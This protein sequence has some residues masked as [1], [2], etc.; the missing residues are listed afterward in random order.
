MNERYICIHGHFYQPPREN[1]WLE[2]IELQ[3]SAFPYHDWNERITAE[4]YES[5]AT[6][7]ILNGD[8]RIES[9]VNNYARISFNFGPTLM[10]WLEG[11]APN[12][13]AA[14]V[15]AD[16][17]STTR[18]GGHGSAMAQCYN[19]SIMPLNNS[20]DKYTQVMWGIRDFTHRFG[21]EPEG[22]WLPE[23]AVDLESLDMMAAAGITFTVLAPR[24]A[25]AVRDKGSLKW[26]DVN[27][28]N[29]DPTMPYECTLPSGR[30]IAIFFYDGPI[31]QGIAFED[32]LASGENLAGRLAGAFNDD[33]SHPQ[34]VHIATDG[35][36]YGHHHYRGEMALSYAL[37][38][39]E[40]NKLANL[41]N[42]A[43]YLEKHPPTREARIYENSSWS[44]IHG[45]ERWRADCGCST[46]GRPGWNQQWRLPL[47]TA[48][49][50]LRDEVAPE[51]EES[52]ATFLRDPW[53][54]RDDYVNFILDR[55]DRNLQ[56]FLESNQIRPLQD[57]EV[58]S[59]L[60]ALE[61]QR[62]AMMMY[63]SCGWFFD[64]L[65]GIETSQVIMYAGRVVQLA[66]ELLELDLEEPFLHKLEA[67]KSN[68]PEHRD[69]RE[70]YLKFVKPAIVGL[71]K[72]G[73]HFAVSSMFRDYDDNARIFAFDVRRIHSKRFEK[74]RTRMCVGHIKV[75]SRITCE[76]DDLTFGVLH[77]GDHNV[78]GGVRRFQ[79]EDAYRKLNEEMDAVLDRA[80]LPEMIRYM[81]ANF[82]AATYSLKSLFKDEQRAI[83]TII[84]K[85]QLAD[86]ETIFRREYERHSPMMRFIDDLFMPLPRPFQTVAEYALTSM[87]NEAFA[88]EELD[89]DRIEALIKDATRGNIPLDTK[90]LEI[91]LRRRLE[92]TERQ[93]LDDP[94]NFTRLE[95]FHRELML[96][97]CMPF[98]INLWEIQNN[99]WGL[100]QTIMHE[101]KYKAMRGD[102]DA[103]R[104]LD[105][106]RKVGDLLGVRTG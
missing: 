78:Y 88:E 63:T 34:I 28:G 44:C 50:W 102:E 27:G 62:H 79:G 103:R 98:E 99:Y 65:S 56:V 54:A 46:G 4:C 90:L 85:D 93:L 83:L 80:D 100:V 87:I 96:I 36:T 97:P 40:S 25:A 42:Y 47:R 91:T 26:Q 16:R 92:Q 33:R 6:S 52:M 37:H 23:C 53:A 17:D 49:D 2:A 89:H 105:I 84:L 51:Y 72:V 94:A 5:N 73:A 68:I 75:A 76:T 1:P 19:H 21:R 59:V 58:V 7:R 8:G 9:I 64:E 66:N 95:Q 81:D 29:I 18:F 86:I 38:F 55:S 3:D 32:L 61:L 57:Q 106:F 74:G 71:P 70:I 22:M 77:L 69:G 24:Q 45:V 11:L 82:S 30:T 39:I 48:L 43:Y 10:E 13:H 101:F 20:R 12:V 15:A 14:I 104:W 60:Q 67:A 31:S 41:T 35:E